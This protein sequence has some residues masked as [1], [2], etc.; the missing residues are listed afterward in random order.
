VQLDNYFA[1]QLGS[2]SIL[3]A[4]TKAAATAVLN[5]VIAASAFYITAPGIKVM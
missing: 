1:A 4:A 3:T 2:G 5:D